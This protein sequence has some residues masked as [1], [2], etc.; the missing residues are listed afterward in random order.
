MQSVGRGA[1]SVGRRVQSVGRG[2]HSVG[3]RVQLV[4]WRVM[5]AS[6]TLTAL[7]MPGVGTAAGT[8]RYRLDEELPPGTVLGQI[9]T[10]ADLHLFYTPQQLS[11]LRYSLLAQP[12]ARGRHFAVDAVT[13]VV[14]TAER[15]DRDVL[16]GAVAPC[17][18]TLDVAVGPA[19]YFRSVP[20]SVEVVDVND[21]APVFPSPTVTCRLPE[22]AAIGASFPLETVAHDDDSAPYGVMRYRLADSSPYFRLVV[23]E[24]VEGATELSLM[25]TA[26]L[27]REVTQ[28]YEVTLIA[29]DGGSP[30]LN[31][32]VL[33]QIH[34]VDVN[35][36]SPVFQQGAYWAS[37]YE[38][39]SVGTE[40]AWVNASDADA[41]DNARLT[42]TF[43]SNTIRKYSQLFTIEPLTGRVLL[44]RP[45]DYELV[46]SYHLVVVARDAG[47]NSRST[48]C[49]LTVDVVDVNDN[50]PLI[51]FS[52][53]T[54]GGRA[55]V[56][57]D[58]FVG[59]FV[60]H[61]SV[62]DDDAG[63]AGNV[64][65]RVGDATSDTFRL[66]QL[67]TTQYAL[68]T[69]VTLDRE[70]R[71][72]YT[73]TVTCHDGGVT[74]LTTTASVIVSV[75]DV[76]DNAPVFSAE[77]YVVSVAEDTPLHTPLLRVMAHDPDLA[78]NG[79]IIFSLSSPAFLIDSVLGDVSAVIALDYEL[80]SSI[81]FEVTAS[82]RGEPPRAARV[83]VTITLTDV[84]D[85]APH[86]LR[87]SYSFGVFEGRPPRSSVG[88]VSSWD[89]DEAPYDAVDYS[90]R[91]ADGADGGAGRAF[92]IDPVSGR[93]TTA[94]ILD[95]ETRP[96]Y[97]LVAVATNRSPPHASATV[98]VSVY[99]LDEND[100]APRF[101]FAG[102]GGW[103]AVRVSVL[104]A[105]G[106][107][108]TRVRASDR[109]RGRNAL[110]TF[111]LAP[112]SPL[113]L[114]DATT[115]ALTLRTVAPPAGSQYNLT[116]VVTD[117]GEPARHASATLSV[118]FDA[119]VTPP[120]THPGRRLTTSNL[121][122][123]VVASV[124]L[125]VI[126]GLIIAII[127]LR[128]MGD[129]HRREDKGPPPA[130]GDDEDAGG[131]EG[132]DCDSSTTMTR[133][134]ERE[135]GGEDGEE[136]G[137]EGGQRGK[138]TGWTG[139]TPAH[140]SAMVSRHPRVGW[141]SGGEGGFRWVRAG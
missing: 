132:S 49:M 25:V 127:M 80:N 1:H 20:V 123:V 32:S 4:G 128:L 65:C 137:R 23:N 125:V 36:N 92:L 19:Q 109:D 67:H 88:S 101:E 31:G 28:E 89:A 69:A 24:D 115:G 74:P 50:A 18:L 94:L 60:A 120:A 9:S 102:G 11:T 118:T 64:T 56:S 133:E 112:P 72:L 71:Q 61:L 41:G 75:T 39:I 105:R 53:L 12:A 84:N 140:Q 5:Y 44:Q 93:V 13:S 121:T 26:G 34:I 17:L 27:D 122:T 29:Q 130:R 6:L 141:R 100:N 110:L 117:G 124:S 43:S 95:R 104:L 54:P 30:P 45:L 90:L 87:D 59:V 46:T 35:D 82:D 15:L 79:D 139:R 8:V 138:W 63:D 96:L 58:A 81:T 83:N 116:V 107:V 51:S 40:V 14:S 48:T 33:V 66:R 21:N 47:L 73:V 106:A 76:N 86:F 114:M 99:L 126:V 78:L 77:E 108:I 91:A 136:G 70:T 55:V 37:V 52:T 134:E 98:P 7:F 135:E 57:E 38:N 3:R 103:G 16:C 85:E 22:S 113:F 10:D 111:S 42:Y 97:R 119:A 62:V 68:V 131:R 2:A 129:R